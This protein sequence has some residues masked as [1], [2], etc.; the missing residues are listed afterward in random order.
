MQVPNPLVPPQL[1]QPGAAPAPVANAPHVP[2]STKHETSRPVTASK[3]AERAKTDDE[4][5]SR[6]AEGGGRRGGRLDIVV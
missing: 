6:P 1:G 5:R 3:Q 2:E 4:R